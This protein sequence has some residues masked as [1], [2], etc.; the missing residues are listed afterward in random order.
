MLQLQKTF[1]ESYMKTLRDA[2][3]SGEALPLYRGDSFAIDEIQVK[4]LANVYAPE[5]LENKLIPTS[6]GDFESGVAVYEAYRNIS[7]LLAS[8]EA[9]W[10]YITHTT[11]YNYAQ[12]RWPKVLDGSASSDYIIDHW[13]IGSQGI[14]RN[15]AAALW[16]GVYLTVDEESSNKYEL[17]E[18]LFRNYTLRVVTLGSYTLIRHRQAM[19]GILEFLKENP[20]ITQRGFEHKGQFITKYFNRL[21]SSK[22]LVYMDKDFFYN[23]LEKIKDRILSIT[24]REDI[25]NDMLYNDI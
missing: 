25:N 12:K 23:T 4:R 24:T 21:G 14:L 16:W 3:K 5:G 8:N 9:F 19:F 10:V 1:K 17:T 15:V 13:F 11:L 2:V 22:Q 18:I 7:P 20:D 6:D